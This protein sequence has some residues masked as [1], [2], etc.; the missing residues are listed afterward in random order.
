M[1]NK[2]DVT[3][4]TGDSL[5]EKVFDTN[6]DFVKLSAANLSEPRAACIDVSKSQS[7]GTEAGN[8]PQR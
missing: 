1:R 4:L 5:E 6:A 2:Y 7:K 3:E 8:K